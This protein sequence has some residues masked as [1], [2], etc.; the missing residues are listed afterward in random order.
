MFL[1]RPAAGA[2]QICCA[3]GVLIEGAIQIEDASDVVF[4]KRL[5]CHDPHG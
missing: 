1:D 2:E 5:A 4:V 3:G